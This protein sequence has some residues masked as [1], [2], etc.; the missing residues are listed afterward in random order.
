MFNSP[1]NDK[2]YHLEN[3]SMIGLW[4]ASKGAFGEKT[5]VFIFSSENKKQAIYLEMAC[6]FTS[7]FSTIT[8][9]CT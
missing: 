2:R 3:Y 7:Y 9:F 4:V 1:L 8:G 5:T 6:S